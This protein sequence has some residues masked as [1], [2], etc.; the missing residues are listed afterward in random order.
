[1]AATPYIGLNCSWSFNSVAI[2]KIKSLSG[3]NMTFGEVETTALGS[4][5][6]SFI[7]TLLEAGEL[8]IEGHY[9]PSDSVHQG[10]TTA[11]LAGTVASNVVTVKS[12]GTPSTYTFQGFIK[13]F[14]PG[15]MTPEGVVSFS[16]TVRATGS[17]T[18]A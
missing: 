6:K 3:L 15:D 13:S 17:V 1:M 10:L 11:F 4:T 18:I 8:Q 12:G 14:S 2:T 9:D 7:P 16:A 5:N